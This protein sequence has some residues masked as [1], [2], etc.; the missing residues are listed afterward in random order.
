MIA[1]GASLTAFLVAALIAFLVEGPREAAKILADPSGPDLKK[2][3]LVRRRIT[4]LSPLVVACWFLGELP[5]L[6]LV[7]VAMAVWGGFVP[8]HRL[9]LNLTRGVTWWYLSPKNGYDAKWLMLFG[10]LPMKTTAGVMYAAELIV[11]AL[12]LW[13]SWLLGRAAEA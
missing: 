12:G 6:G 7:A 11:A 10:R 9:T 3:P 8:V 2:G 13:C 4:I 1:F 5:A